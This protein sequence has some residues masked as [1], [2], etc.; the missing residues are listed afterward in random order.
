[1]FLTKLRHLS[2]VY[3][4]SNV[5]QETIRRTKIN[6]PAITHTVRT[7]ARFID[8]D[9][10]DAPIGRTRTP[11]RRD[12]FNDRRDSFG[13]RRDSFGG[14]RGSFGGQKGSFNQ[15]GG[16]FVQRAGSFGN[17]GGFGD[18]GGSFGGQRSSFGQ[19]LNAVDYNLDELE[20]LEKNF[21]Q[22]SEITAN[23][24]EAE[25]NAFREKH[26]ISVPRDVPKPIFTFKELQNLPPALAR[27]IQR[28]NFEDC[29]PI[30]AQGMPIALSGQNMVG[31]AQTGSGKTLAYIV[32]AIIH[33]L[34]QAPLEVNDG[35]IALVLAPTRELAQQIQKV[36][37]QFG[38]SSNINN[39]ALYGGSAKAQ[40]LSELRMGAQFVVATPGRLID[41]LSTNCVNL[42][43]CSYLVL[44]EAD[45]ML[46][47]GF[48]PQMRQIVSQIRPDR[49]TVMWSATWPRE[50]R[51]IARDF[52]G[53]E[54]TQLTVGSTELCANHN[55]KQVIR[56]CEERDK[57]RELLQILENVSKLERSD[58]KTIIFVQTKR[59]ADQLSYQLS[60][61]GFKNQ[62]IHG[63]RSQAQR[64]MTLDSFRSNRI[65][66]LIATD[67]AARGLDVSD[68]KNVIN[69][70]YPNTTEDYVHRIGRT[71]RS[72]SHGTAYTLFT[73]ENYNQADKLI[74]VLSEAKQ[75]IAPELLEL[76]GQRFGRKY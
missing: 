25:I 11:Q 50:V 30:Q 52:L 13:G 6:F 65:S 64:E 36:A 62:P 7:Y 45:R 60:N 39:A 42:R 2:S 14:Q 19:H 28:E 15:R 48:E 69:Y 40:Q 31:I 22:Q 9:D 24:T 71:G 59:M 67:V 63:G 10:D 73:Q 51:N 37:T 4:R 27:E 21:Y 32:P 61:R 76:S 29:T 74:A 8:D 68:I 56:V 55:I 3:H 12:S 70:D 54:Y 38:R 66:T 23:R 57:F 16:S 34:N 33:I 35:P 46:D 47:M 75:D 20:S 53:D 72:K 44:D 41:L 26:E 43:R 49:Q 18:R 58:Q 1:M 5:V 17:Q